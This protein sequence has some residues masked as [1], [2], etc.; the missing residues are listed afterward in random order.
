MDCRQASMH[1][2]EHMFLAFY[3]NHHRFQDTHKC[4]HTRQLLLITSTASSGSIAVCVLDI[5]T[6]TRKQLYSRHLT[7]STLLRSATLSHSEP[8]SI[9]AIY[10]SLVNNPNMEQSNWYDGLNSL[11]PLSAFWFLCAS[12][13]FSLSL[14]N[15]R[16]T[17]PIS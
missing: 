5:E 16:S 13:F 1:P 9:F 11:I 3:L 6:S 12:A 8:F 2:S 7:H 4:A 17:I 14:H 15:L 10:G